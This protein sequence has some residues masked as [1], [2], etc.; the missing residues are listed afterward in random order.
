MDK[1]IHH[2]FRIL[3]YLGFPP[4]FCLTVN[5]EGSTYGKI[6]LPGVYFSI[7]ISLFSCTTQSSESE[8]QSAIQAQPPPNIILIL[9]DDL[10]AGDL[11]CTG[12][13]YVKTPNIDR[14]A[15]DG[16]M[17]SNAYMAA[18]WCAPTRYSLMR[19]QFPARQFYQTYN[20]LPTEPS[21]TKLLQ[22]AGYATAH[23]GKWHM[24]RGDSI[25]TDPGDFGLDAHFTTSSSGPGWT[26]E[27]RQRPYHRAKTTD[28]YVDMTIDFIKENQDQP[29]YINLWVH[30]TH[31][32]IDPSP[33]QLAVYEGLKVD[34]EDFKSSYQ[35]QY[36]EFVSEYGNLDKAMQAYCADITGMDQ[37]IGRLMAYLDQNNL[38]ENTILVFTSDNGPGPLTQQIE[39]R[40]VV[41]RFK[42]RPTLLNS[43]GSAGIFRDRKLSIHEGGI[44]VPFI[45]KWAAS[46]PAG[47]ID[48]KTVIGSVD[49]L[50]TIA[51]ICGIELP[52]Y[53]YDGVDMTAAFQ[54]QETD[55]G[56][57]LF[58]LENNGQAAILKGAWKGV[59][60]Q[61]EFSLYNVEQDPEEDN[62]LRETYRD[63]AE[64][65]RS[66]LESWLNEVPE[67]V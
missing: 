65:I 43:V 34:I 2:M 62:D 17:F 61:G 42:E 55:R 52:D 24:S 22:D 13:P 23:F 38:A 15:S 66:E 11:A 67:P 4:D 12:H 47:R 44:H 7:A 33:E 45:V 37:A 25:S 31:S 30:P 16:I 8:N 20:L 35:Q 63:K 57:P 9:A 36:L 40:S 46:T 14:L 53:N 29:F 64:E 28:G 59:I 58:W 60:R 51:S 5:K 56:K 54:G 19:G 32:Y 6:L 50:P 10:G 48:A 3:S 18:A 26:R 49:W 1:F 21:I 39:N 41:K 27:Q